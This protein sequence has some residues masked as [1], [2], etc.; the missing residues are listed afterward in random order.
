MSGD[1]FCG[2]FRLNLSSGRLWDAT[3]EVRLTPKAGAVLQVLVSHAGDP[4]SKQ[5]LFD[6]VWPDTSVSDDA[7]TS[8]IQELRRAFKDNPRQPRFIETRHRRGYWRGRRSRRLC[9]G[10][11]RYPDRGGRR[12]RRCNRLWRRCPGRRSSSVR[13]RTRSRGSSPGCSCRRP[14]QTA[15]ATASSTASTAAACA[16]RATG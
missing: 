11:D 10:A 8:C 3:E 13:P 9:S 12:W 2:G 4:V 1:L 6:A 5:Q 7:L 16:A 14:R 15:G